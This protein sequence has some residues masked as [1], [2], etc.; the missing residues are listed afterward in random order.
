MQTVPDAHQPA[1]GETFGIDVPTRYPAATHHFINGI[2]AADS[3]ITP[4]LFRMSRRTR[5]IC[6]VLVALLMASRTAR[7]DADLR[8]QL[9][10]EIA[11]GLICLL[12]AV[13]SNIR[14]LERIYLLGGGVMMIGNALMTQ[15]DG[16]VSAS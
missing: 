6:R 13:F 9:Q 16:A 15:V 1:F 11:A 5:F 14:F 2:M 12:A 10:L 8:R 4:T 3:S 7:T